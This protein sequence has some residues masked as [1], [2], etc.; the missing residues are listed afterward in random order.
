MLRLLTFGGLA[1]ENGDPSAAPKLRPPRLALLAVLAAAGERGCTRERLTGLFWPEAGEDHGRHSLRQAL[2]GLRSEIGPDAIVAGSSLALNPAFLISDVT[3]FR[4]ALEAGDRK[5][6]VE[7]Y[8]GA[9]L[10]GF[11]LS[12]TPEFE[13]WSEQER[14][15]LAAAQSTALLSL[16]NEAAGSGNRDEAAHWWYRLAL[17]EPLS[18]RVAVGYIRALCSCGDRAK[19]LAFI[20]SH[21]AAI[22]REL[23][24]APDPEIRKL[25]A[26][27]RAM[28]DSEVISTS[29]VVASTSRVVAAAI[30][31]RKPAVSTQP[32]PELP[33]PVPTRRTGRLAAAIALVAIVATIGVV[34]AG[35]RLRARADPGSTDPPLWNATTSSPIASRFYQEGIRAYYAWDWEAARRLMTAALKED[36]TFA[37]ASYVS[38]LLGIEPELEMR[39]RALRLAR[40]APERERLTILADLMSGDMEPEGLA[41][42]EEAATLY[43][44]DGRIAVA[45]ALARNAIGDWAG[46]VEAYERAIRLYLKT[47]RNREGCLACQAFGQMAEAYQWWDSLPAAERTMKRFGE[48]YPRD[49]WPWA[50]LAVHGAVIGDSAASLGDL[51]RYLAL[52]P[53]TL[54][55]RHELTVLL[56]LEQYDRVEREV[57]PLLASSR[58][59]DTDLGRWYLMIA[60]RNQGRLTDATE[61]LR[62]GR[63]PGSSAPASVPVA[64]DNTNEAVIAFESGNPRRAAGYFEVLRQAVS[65]ASAP[66]QLARRMAW[67]TTLKATALAALGDTATVRHLADTVEYWGKRSLYGRDRKAHHF[68]RGLLRAAA[69]EHVEAVESFRAAIHSTTFG[70]TRVNYELARCLLLLG[71]AEEA[72]AVLQPALRGSPEASNLYVTR[73]ELHELLAQAFE[74]AGR[75][76]SAAAHY[77]AVV[78][79]WARADARFI[80]RREAAR[81]RINESLASR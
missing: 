41:I 16:A 24:A 75:P 12:G 80:P 18:A 59:G 57:Q 9:F 44:H 78:R 48:A 27:L 33:A 62:T 20:R 52:T 58:Q 51:R 65:P 8:R 23:D 26:E 22:R 10:D 15:R 81:R 42:A 14:E 70:Y 56:L 32:D 63:L 77:G 64:V 50:M 53:S 36:S 47:E 25:E 1:L 68:L 74:Q 21:E 34:W 6:A 19:A 55:R 30:D 67:Y 66:G 46:A 71:R 5:R 40:N 54:L 3:Q 2:Y 61:M 45:Q 69:G 72:V 60:L 31:R 17:H 49:G 35:Q 43:P 7:L 73:T 38:V 37:M 79:A 28:P 13:R 11:Y 76:D 29:R 4:V 39:R